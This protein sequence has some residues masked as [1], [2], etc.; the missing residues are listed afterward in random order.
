METHSLCKLS[1][2][3]I[4]FIYNTTAIRKIHL[5]IRRETI[6]MER[7]ETSRVDRQWPSKHLTMMSVV[8]KKMT[9]CDRKNKLKKGEGSSLQNKT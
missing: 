2:Q 1:R 7:G 3:Q 4:V 5:Y 6:I 8:G 9:S